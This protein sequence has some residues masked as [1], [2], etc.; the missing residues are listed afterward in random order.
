ML[1]EP[2]LFIDLPLL[3]LQ[4]LKTDIRVLLTQNYYEPDDLDDLVDQIMPTEDNE[5]LE[6]ALSAPELLTFSIDPEL[7]ADPLAPTAADILYAALLTELREYA[8]EWIIN[9]H[10]NP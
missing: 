5:L 9:G 1:F 7:L 10:N 8:E 3:T 4:G 2:S 6:I